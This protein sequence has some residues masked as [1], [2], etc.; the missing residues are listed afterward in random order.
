MGSTKPTRRTTLSFGPDTLQSQSPRFDA[1]FNG[2]RDLGYVN[3]RTIAI[4]YLSADGRGERFPALASDCVRLKTDIIVVSTTP[5]ARAAKNAT[6]TI[7]ILMIAL[8]DPVGTG[9]VDSLAQPGGNVTGMSLMV[10]E[11]AAKRL[12][13]LKGAVPGLSR[14]LVLSYLAD[15][16]GTVTSDGTGGGGSFDWRVDAGSGHRLSYGT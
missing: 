1:F 2:L 7:P 9:L 6:R 12:G 8:G 5:A 14:V 3:E 4:E 11:L 15:P 13:L 10:P 16:I